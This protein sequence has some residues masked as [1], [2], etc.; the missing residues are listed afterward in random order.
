MPLVH[1]YRR[2]LNPTI[3]MRMVSPGAWIPDF[4]PIRRKWAGLGASWELPIAAFDSANVKAINDAMTAYYDARSRGDQATAQA[5]LNAANAVK[6][7]TG[8]PAVQ[9][10][11]SA[12][13]YAMNAYAKGLGPHPDSGIQPGSYALA[14]NPGWTA[15][16]TPPDDSWRAAGDQYAANLATYQAAHPELYTNAATQQQTPATQQQVQNTSAPAGGSPS[17]AT[18]IQQITAK[19]Q[20]MPWYVLAAAG[21]GLILVLKK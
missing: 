4:S 3:P 7:A 16:T 21:A 19:V 11:M 6:V 9:D 20:E 14:N 10:T 15:T 2:P 12:Y 18:A 13:D 8:Q 17:T 5:A 1:S